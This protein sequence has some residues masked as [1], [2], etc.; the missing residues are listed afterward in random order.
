[1][2]FRACL[3][4]QIGRLVHS[5][6][7]GSPDA[8]SRHALFIETR[9]S[10]VFG[11]LGFIPFYLVGGGVPGLLDAVLLAWLTAPLFAVSL[12]SATG[13]LAW[14]ESIV[15]VG[16]IG[17]AA[18]LVL[19][20]VCGPGSAVALLLILP[21]EANF[22]GHAGARGVVC[23]FT[24]CGTV[25]LLLAST[26]L[27]DP[28][29][30][31]ATDAFFLLLAVAYSA[32][33]WVWGGSFEAAHLDAEA[34]GVERRQ[35]TIEAIG[36]LLVRFDRSGAVLIN[37]ARA[38]ALLGIDPRELT[39]RG[40]FERVH[41]AD[42]PAFL[43]LI[44]DG[45]HSDDV[46]AGRVRVRLS[47][48]PTQDGGFEQPAFAPIEMSVR[49]M[50]SDVQA[51]GEHAGG[52]AALAV[53]RNV[54]EIVARETA[55][56]QA[57]RDTAEDSAWRDRFLATLSHELRTPLNAIIGFGEILASETHA[58]KQPEKRR[59]YAHIIQ[60]SGQH[61]LAVVNSLLDLSKIDAGKFDIL[62]EPFDLG[63][64]VTSCCD[65][66]R[67]KA[68]QARIDL[69]QVVEPALSEVVGDKRVYRQII[70]NL[71]SN[72]V[73]FTP[74]YGNVV[75]EAR[76]AATMLC[77]S[78]RDTGIGIMPP[79]MMRLGDPFFQAQHAF[80]RRFEGTGLGL[81]IVRGL[82]GLHG[83]A[84]T[85]QSTPGEGTSIVV[86]LPCDGRLSVPSSSKAKIEIIPAPPQPIV[87]HPK[88]QPTKVKKIA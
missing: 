49:S 75:L 10:L 30:F 16:W 48:P 69:R 66:V 6:A 39:G 22:S 38:H 36:D 52:P 12:G 70:L 51:S 83:G 33:L 82:V 68:E 74:E 32:M 40:F 21:V 53:V 47:L 37:E 45:T 15:Q 61:L 57:V 59:E 46:V 7:Q 62:L 76:R 67:L 88:F 79:D 64:L 13:R 56:S 43:K 24:V 86:R 34:I 19:G 14:A 73:K 29:G 58:P 25:L 5:S 2:T 9:L 27:A 85:A 50:A 65:M 44:S 71:L 17:L 41:V 31:G 4:D 28:V 42:R 80:D 72:A 84:I 55:A 18:T 3:E 8:A 35:A 63:A 20:R 26:W 77:I 78:V 87:Q 54:T 60:T 81:S 1:M 11:A 23:A